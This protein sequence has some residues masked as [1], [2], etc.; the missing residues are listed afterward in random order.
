[1]K[2]AVRVLQSPLEI[3]KSKIE[4]VHGFGTGLY[5]ALSR[6]EG[7]K[8]LDSIGLSRRHGLSKPSP[9]GTG[10]AGR[11]P[12]PWPFIFAHRFRLF[13]PSS[14]F[15][16]VFPPPAS[17]HGSKNPNQTKPNR[18]EPNLHS[19]FD[20]TI[21]PFNGSTPSSHQSFSTFFHLFPPFSTSPPSLR[22]SNDTNRLR[23][24]K[25]N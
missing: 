22:Q 7:T 11:W 21:Q 2:P 25:P 15:F 18:D 4:N 20:S 10:E 1:M 14:G 24:I 12:G 17:F 13:P 9:G 16:H 23:Q 8:T 5:T 3:Q 19:V 6:P